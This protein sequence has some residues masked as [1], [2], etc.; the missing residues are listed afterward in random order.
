MP[1][2]PRMGAWIEMARTTRRT[3]RP[4]VA[5]VWGR[6]LKYVKENCQ[7]GDCRVAPVW[8]RGLKS[9]QEHKSSVVMPSPPYG[10]VDWN[11]VVSVVFF[12]AWCRPRMGAWIEI[13]GKATDTVGKLR[14]PRMGA[15]IEITT[16]PRTSAALP[17]APVWGRGL[18]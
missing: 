16:N 4:A 11:C 5:P 2:R 6:G 14:R 1:R 12:G 13:S 15:W 7:D 18:K 9:Q 17:V 3:Q 10:G 8:G